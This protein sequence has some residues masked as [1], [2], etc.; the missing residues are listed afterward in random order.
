MVVMP[1][2]WYRP[3]NTTAILL[4][5]LQGPYPLGFRPAQV[6]TSGA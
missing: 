6:S 2:S 3:G 5:P 1:F 4:M